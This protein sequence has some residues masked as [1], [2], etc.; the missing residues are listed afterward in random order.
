MKKPS[1][2]AIRKRMSC[3]Y[4]KMLRILAAASAV[5]A[6]LLSAA[7]A[8]VQP[9]AAT[10]RF[11]RADTSEV[12]ADGPFFKGTSLLLTNCVLYSGTTTNV[13]QDLT[14]C[15]ITCKVGSVTS[16]LITTNGVIQSAA[17]GT[18]WARFTVPTNLDNAAIL[19]VSVYD[20]NGNSYTY[21][22]KALPLRNPL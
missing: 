20:Q 21:N 19:Q 18:W 10:I 12:V 14:S 5:V 16:A 13:A 15:T 8:D 11:V 22:W 2:L 3:N 4:G 6:A 9:A 7:T 17:N 1:V